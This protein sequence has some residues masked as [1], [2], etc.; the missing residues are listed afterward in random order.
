MC[1]QYK[2]FGLKLGAFQNLW[3]QTLFYANFEQNIFS[4]ILKACMVKF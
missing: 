3:K 4:L 2:P 1:D